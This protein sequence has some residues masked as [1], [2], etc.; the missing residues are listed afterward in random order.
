MCW[1]KKKNEKKNKKY[2]FYSEFSLGHH[3]D[4]NNDDNNN[5]NNNNNNIL[6]SNSHWGLRPT[7]RLLASLSFVRREKDYPASFGLTCGCRYKSVATQIPH[8]TLL[9][10]S[11]LS[12][13]ESNIAACEAVT[14]PAPRRRTWIHIKNIVSTEIQ[15]TAPLPNYN[16]FLN[17]AKNSLETI[18]ASIFTV[19]LRKYVWN[20]IQLTTWR[21]V[22]AYLIRRS[23]FH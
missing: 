1:K 11:A 19:F 2:N 14:S 18:V 23:A 4:T 13:M 21:Q 15:Q 22:A 3:L 9:G 16:L 8:D 6:D 12:E 10:P 7:N 20:G 17:P 5:N